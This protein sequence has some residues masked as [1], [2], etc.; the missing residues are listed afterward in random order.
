VT[1]EKGKSGNPGGRPSGIIARI[2]DELSDDAIKILH[3]MRDIALGGQ[4]DGY[5]VILAK[6]RIKCGEVVTDRVLGKPVQQIDGGLALGLPPDQVALLMALRLTP[7]E[8]R[9]RLAEIDAEDQ[10]EIEAA[11]RDADK[12]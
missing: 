6:D 2:R 12:E 5:G 11:E 10:R 9:R 1:F 3:L 4:P 8:Q 7:D